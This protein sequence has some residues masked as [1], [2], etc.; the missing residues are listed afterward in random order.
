MSV[1]LIVIMILNKLIVMAMKMCLK[2]KARAKELMKE[3]EKCRK[4]A[5]VV[6]HNKIFFSITT[7]MITDIII[8]TIIVI[9]TM[10]KRC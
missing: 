9:K 6:L 2:V 8:I 1:L 10:T 5:K 4:E 3:G 7:T